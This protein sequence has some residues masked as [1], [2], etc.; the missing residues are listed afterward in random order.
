MNNNIYMNNKTFTKLKHLKHFKHFMS[1]IYGVTFYDYAYGSIPT[2]MSGGYFSSLELALKNL[3]KLIPESEANSN[4]KR[5]IC[6]LDGH[7]TGWISELEVDS[8]NI[9]EKMDIHEAIDL[10]EF[11]F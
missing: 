4:N 8:L 2:V 7:R 6:S 9:K 3:R 11:K 1:K 10:R 5:C